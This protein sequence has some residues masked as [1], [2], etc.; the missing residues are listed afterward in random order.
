MITSHQVKSIQSSWALVAPISEQAAALF[1]NRLFELDPSLRELFKSDLTEQG[2]KLMQML[3][4]VV[5]GLANPDRLLP[6]VRGLGARHVE[7]GVEDSQYETVGT[8]LLWTLEQ[9]LGKAF[10]AEVKE[11][12][13]AAYTVLANEMKKGAHEA[14]VMAA[15]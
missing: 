13:T 12:W 15:A 10:T 11:A 3:A 14:V 5:H 6:G 9:G 8:A 1:Y 2:K 7:Y 4:V